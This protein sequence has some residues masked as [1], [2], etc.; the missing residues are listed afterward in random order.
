M[1]TDE[2]LMAP[3]KRIPFHEIAF[4]PLSFADPTGRL[5]R[6]E[7][8]MYRAIKPSF[9]S[10]YQRLFDDHVI[11]NLVDRELLIETDPTLFQLDGY[12]M[13]LRHR[14][15]QFVSYPFEW[16]YTMLRD[17]ALT[18]IEIEM[19]L[20]KYRLGLRDAHPWNIIF[21]GPKPFFVDVGSIAPVQPNTLWAAQDEFYRF[22]SYPLLLMSLGYSR[23]ARSLLPDFDQGVMKSDISILYYNTFVNRLKRI[24]AT[25]KGRAPAYLREI[26]LLRKG[27]AFLK[28]GYL[29]SEG[30]T[31]SH[32]S[33][34]RALKHDIEHLIRPRFASNWAE[35][36][37]GFYPSFSPC[38]EW[39]AKHF[40][41]YRVLSELRPDSLLDIGSNRGWYAHMAAHLG[42]HVVAFDRDEACIDPLYTEARKGGCSILP[43]L[44][45][46]KNPSPGYG[47]CNRWLAPAT[48]RFQ[49]DMVFALALIHHLVFRQHLMFDQILEGLTIFLKRW[50]LIEF[51]P[52]D[53]HYVREWRSRD[54]GWYTLENFIQ[55][56]NKFFFSAKVLPSYP[57]PRVLLLCE[58]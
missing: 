18:L 6:W 44:M 5:F 56:L 29:S 23:I 49:C 51:I 13:V 40:T 17:A 14:E 36:Y 11:H 57:E 19:E 38:A 10:F 41:A 9:V 52:A 15:I 39:T 30:T 42:I 35:Y 55:S 47:L 58:K 25:A 26:P 20:A 54:L 33:S 28:S 3:T 34:V 31:P 48:E 12:G 24:Y 7:G 46:F 4:H 8:Q 32:I 16:C 37:D 27:V 22:F 1:G 45:D 2:G 43:L 53:D 21:D 50:L